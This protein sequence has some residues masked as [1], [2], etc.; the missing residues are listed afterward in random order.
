MKT[1][2]MC[3]SQ[4]A[5]IFLPRVMFQF[6]SE[7]SLREPEADR[8]CRRPHSVPFPTKSAPLGMCPTFVGIAKLVLPEENMQREVMRIEIL[9]A[10]AMHIWIQPRA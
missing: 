6:P 10:H 5:I 8:G 9:D 7:V 4:W 3:S 1:R 2:I